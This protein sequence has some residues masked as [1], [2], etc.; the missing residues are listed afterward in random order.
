MSLTHG[1]PQHENLV[2]GNNMRN[3]VLFLL[4]AG[5]AGA[6]A[7]TGTIAGVV[8]D[9][10][11]AAVVGARLKAQ[12]VTT[13]VLR[14]A[15]TTEQGDYSFPA[16]LAGEYEVSVEASGFQR[17]ARTASVEAGASTMSDFALRVGEVSES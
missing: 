4:L 5:C 14:T 2:Q 3:A 15:I 12:S 11:G 9:P 17:M 10:S 7:P 13:A 8:R 1:Q 6:Q 16:L